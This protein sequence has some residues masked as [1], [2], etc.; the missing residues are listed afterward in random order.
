[1]SYFNA[2]SLQLK[3]LLNF[4][5]IFRNIIFI[6]PLFF[7]GCGTFYKSFNIQQNLI[8]DNINNYTLKIPTGYVVPNNSDLTSLERSLYFSLNYGQTLVMKAKNKSLLFMVIN[9]VSSKNKSGL[10]QLFS[11]LENKNDPKTILT[12]ALGKNDRMEIS[13]SDSNVS[14]IGK[15][16]IIKSKVQIEMFEGYIVFGYQ[17]IPISE[18][19]IKESCII[20]LAPYS[21]KDVITDTLLELIPN[22]NFNAI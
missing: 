1:M 5:T 19:K 17:Y 16:R 21:E 9:K 6:F 22:I 20:H 10:Y 12:Q 4:W 7:L 3:N 2:I 14:E 15:F 18:N 13:F 8:V 11:K